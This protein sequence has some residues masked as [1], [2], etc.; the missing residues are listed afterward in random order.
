[1][2]IFTRRTR[3]SAVV[4][5]PVAYGRH[6]AE[7]IALKAVVASM[8]QT[9]AI[10]ALDE[11]FQKVSVTLTPGQALAAFKAAN[12]FP[13]APVSAIDD[14]LEAQ[15]RATVVASM[16]DFRI[17]Q[18]G[19]VAQI[20]EEISTKKVSRIRRI[21]AAGRAVLARVAR[22]VAA[23]VRAPKVLIGRLSH[24]VLAPASFT[25]TDFVT[26]ATGTTEAVHA[27]VKVKRAGLIR[28]AFKAAVRAL[29]LVALAYA[30]GMA[31]L[32]AAVIS[33]VIAGLK[34]IT[35]SAAVFAK[36]FLLAFVLCAAA[37][38]LPLPVFLLVFAL[39]LF[40]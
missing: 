17:S 39:V 9:A 1:M 3:K 34:V 11:Q 18:E 24:R 30:C 33:A 6:A 29:E 27:E 2:S 20:T 8:D 4:E 25:V 35:R 32:G 38:A 31:L 40:V 13:A 19:M 36:F 15:I 22:K 5:A 37:A 23:V 10:A 12:P 21:G 28:R 14:S 16:N 26:D 7:A